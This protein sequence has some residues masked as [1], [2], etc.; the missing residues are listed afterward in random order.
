MRNDREKWR[1]RTGGF[2][3]KGFFGGM[4]LL[5]AA[6]G[7][8]AATGFAD[9]RLHVQ[10]DCHNIT[11][12]SLPLYLGDARAAGADAVQITCCSL[13][14]AEDE[15][16]Q[17]LE[18]L[19]T[20]LAAAEKAGFATAVWTSSFGYG[21]RLKG[22][23]SGPFAHSTRLTAL[24]GIAHRDA[25]CPLDPDLRAALARNVRD[26]IAAGARFILW[27]DDY[28]QCGRHHICCT[29]P[30]HLA[31]VRRR[32]GRDVTPADIR[33]S[34]CGGPNVLR[35]AFL[36]AN[37]E[38][39]IS[40]ARELRAVADAV[41]PGIGMGLCATYT[42]YDI[43]GTDAVELVSAFAGDGPK[44]LRLSGATYWPYAGSE[45]Y[46]G[47]GLD[48]VLESMRFQANLLRGRGF[49][50]TKGHAPAWTGSGS[51]NWGGAVVAAGVDNVAY[52]IDCV[53]TNNFAGRGAGLFGGTAIRCRF[54]ENGVAT[55]GVDIMQGRAWNCI[56]GNIVNTGG[57]SLCSVY[58]NGPYVIRMVRMSTVRSMEGATPRMMRASISRTFG[59]ALW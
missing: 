40:L 57:S 44:L 3:R 17:T 35:T 16:R 32:I 39:M 15:R 22:P 52:I 43:E 33:A 6:L 13:T 54:E 12:K 47:Q 45:R 8:H 21:A 55:T 9:A 41:A 26:F 42:L 56:F 5:V 1:V 48:G 24:D 25:I 49:T 38:A 30:R 19:R 7:L 14:Q 37:R 51:G 10:I 18:T 53:I 46:P 2:A 36:D 59:T 27:D 28:I 20:A 58:Q 11:A 29:C 50:L 4:M 23:P 34:F 31:L